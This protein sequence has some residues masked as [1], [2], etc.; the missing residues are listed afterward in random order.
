MATYYNFALRIE[1][2]SPKRVVKPIPE[3]RKPMML[4]RMF[5]LFILGEK[6]LKT[7][8]VKSYNSKCTKFVIKNKIRQIKCKI[9]R[10]T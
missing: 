1:T 2:S 5:G 3:S 9:R 6:K 8:N 10:T 7:Y 4:L